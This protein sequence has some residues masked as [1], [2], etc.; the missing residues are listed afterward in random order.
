MF[1]V[2]LGFA[3]LQ[4]KGRAH[5]GEREYGQQGGGRAVGLSDVA[6]SCPR[7]RAAAE[8]IECERLDG[9]NDD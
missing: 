6:A 7:I 4:D 9:D 5:V 8:E 3:R 1:P 2:R